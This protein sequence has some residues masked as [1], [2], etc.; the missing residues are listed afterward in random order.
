MPWDSS[1]AQSYTRKANTPKKRRQ[2]SHV[3]N[4]AMSRGD[5]EGSAIRQANAAVKRNTGRTI[6]PKRKSRRY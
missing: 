5:D 6:R 1:D 3:A 4:S 2:F